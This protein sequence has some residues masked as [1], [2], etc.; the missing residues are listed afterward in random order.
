MKRLFILAAGVLVL[1]ACNKGPSGDSPKEKEHVVKEPVSVEFPTPTEAITKVELNEQQKGFVKAG[2]WMAM[3]LLAKM[4]EGGSFICSPLSLQCALAMTANGASG[5]TLKEMTDFLGFGEEGV[6][7]MN[8]FHKTLLEQLPAVDLG[9]KLK[10]TDAL[11]VNEKFPLQPT[12]QATVQD[13]YYAVVENDDFSDS[14]HVAGRIND[15]ASRST[16]GFIDKVLDASELSPT[17]AAYIM[18]ALYFKAKWAGSE[19]NPMFQENYTQEEQFTL[20]NGSTVRLPLM[21]TAGRYHFAKKDGYRVLALPYADWKYRLFIL[22]PDNNDLD[23]LIKKMADVSWTDLQGSLQRTDVVVKLP[24][25]DIENRFDLSETLQEMGVRRAFGLDGIAQF[26]R[27]FTASEDGFEFLIGKVW[28]KARISV[29]EWGT[30]A[31]AVTVV[32]MDNATSGPPEEEPKIEYFIA[33]H[34]FLFVLGEVT[35]G[36]I[37]FEGAFTGK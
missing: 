12:F 11:L 26:D 7:A 2:D 13:S 3:R 31:A 27:M 35:S 28:Q 17:A 20:S 33:D 18:N 14:E 15:W 34:P 23:A 5:E 32:E 25:F 16:D 9:V 10:L 22:L 4:Y 8:A 6:D 21:N 37:L 29:A 30:E 24:R 1:A 36:T 19:D